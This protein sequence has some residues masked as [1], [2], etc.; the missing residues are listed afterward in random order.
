MAARGASDRRRGGSGQSRISCTSPARGRVRVSIGSVPGSRVVLYHLLEAPGGDN[1]ARMN[2]AVQVSCRLLNLL[3]DL[4]VAVKVE[5]VGDQV[6]GILIVLDL[7]LQT[8]QVETVG[9]VLLID[10]AK[11]LVTARGD[12]PVPPV[13]CVVGVGLRV[14]VVHWARARSGS[15]D[16]RGECGADLL[17]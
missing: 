9:Q 5:D 2:Q 16:G 13:G 6:Q 8:R 1:V 10:L 17:V 14:I 12:E 7:R 15:E 4:V 11:V 3:A